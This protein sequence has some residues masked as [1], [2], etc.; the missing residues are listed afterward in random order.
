MKTQRQYAIPLNR[1]EWEKQLIR[2]IISLRLPLR[3]VN[4]VEFQRSYLCLDSTAHLPS[5]NT[6]KAR[7]LEQHQDVRPKLLKAFPRDGTKI[8][9]SCDGWSSK[10]KQSYL[11]INAYFIDPDWNY[12]E[13][14]LAFRHIEG[15]HSGA[16][17]ADII[18][19][20]LQYH[21]IR[22]FGNCNHHR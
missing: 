11:A 2:A 20:E 21:G 4:D 18:L 19:E 17:M 22:T 7:I 5:P 14:L 16:N 10:N 3:C 12:H 15:H 9:I 8:S 6:V 1:D 13:V